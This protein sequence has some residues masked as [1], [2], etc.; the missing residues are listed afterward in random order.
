MVLKATDRF[1]RMR[2]E[3]RFSFGRAE[4]LRDTEESS[5]S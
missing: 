5:L 3:K 2:K 4:S 1:R